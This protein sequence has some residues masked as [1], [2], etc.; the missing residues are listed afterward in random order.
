MT[1]NPHVSFVQDIVARTLKDINLTQLSSSID[2]FMKYRHYLQIFEDSE[3]VEIIYKDKNTMNLFA[4]NK[5]RE[6]MNE[7]GK[8]LYIP[9][10]SVVPNIKM[11]LSVE[12]IRKL[13]LKFKN[14]IIDNEFYMINSLNT[15]I[16]YVSNV[17]GESL[18]R[19]ILNSNEW[20]VKDFESANKE[21]PPQSHCSIVTVLLDEINN[22]QRINNQRNL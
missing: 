4:E 21:K 9:L 3:I 11:I 13:G 1:D 17:D 20:S 19:I 2:L 6:Y 18:V 8:K 10:D 14:C 12:D 22:W 15:R 7:L 16:F 5:I